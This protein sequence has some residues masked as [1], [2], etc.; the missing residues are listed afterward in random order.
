M[1][2]AI[3]ALTGLILSGCGGPGTLKGSRDNGAFGF[4]TWTDPE[5]GCVYIVWREWEVLRDRDYGGMTAQ[6]RA[7][8]KPNCP[9]VK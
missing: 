6:L 4:N 1:K 8:G 7:D 2:Y 9:E 5:S 3:L